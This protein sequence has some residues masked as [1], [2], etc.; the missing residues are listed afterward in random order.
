MLIF[1]IRKLLYMIPIVLGV[2]LITFLLFNVVGGNPAYQYAG[3]NATVEQIQELERELGIDRPLPEQYLFYLQQIV[4]FD[5][6]RSWSTKQKISTMLLD[7][8][9]ASLSLTIPPFVIGIFLS[10]SIALYATRR[11]GSAI[12]KGL[13]IFCLAG[14]S[15]SALVY[16]IFFQ[17]VLGYWLGWFEITGYDPDLVGRWKYLY[18]PWIIWI[19]VSLGSS[20]LFYRTLFLEEMFQDYVRTARAKG[21]GENRIYYSHILKNA[22]IP[23][24]TLVVMELPALLTGSLLLEAFFA[25]PG[26][27]GLLIKALQSSDFPVIKAMTFIGTFLYIIANILSDIAYAMVDP[28]IKLQ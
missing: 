25:I 12:D 6:G 3:K 28:R 17:Y 21:L 7:G 13:M 27:G 9:G 16:I 23:I 18:M 10:I 4:T 19:V 2:T 22:M 20:I 5:F 26:I 24:I 8:M 1:I 15:I 11:R 14:M